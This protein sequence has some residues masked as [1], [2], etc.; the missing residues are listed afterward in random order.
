MK[1]ICEKYIKII[2]MIAIFIFCICIKNTS[3]AANASISSNATVEQGKTINISVN[4]SGVQWYLELKIDG[5]T[6]A[7]SSELDNYES[8]KN[9]SFSYSYTPQTMGIKNITLVGSV[10][11]FDDGS[12]ITSFAGK[13]I[14]VTE[15]TQE[16]PDP[17]VVDSQPAKS[18]GNT[19]AQKAEPVKTK[20]EEKKSSEASLKELIIE[21]EGLMPEF[22]ADVTEYTINVPNEITALNITATPTDTKA[23]VTI[24]GNENFVV[25]ENKVIIKVVAED[26]TTKEYVINV[27]RKR[28]NLALASL[29]IT[30]IDKDGNTQEIIL[31][32]AFDGA[33]LEYNLGDISYLIESLNI[34][35]I[36]NLEGAIVEIS[37][38]EN[39]QE[40]ENIITIKLTMKAE[41]AAE[42]EE[43]EEDE[44][45]I[46]TIKLNKE[47]EPTFWEKLKDKIKGIFG[48]ISTWFN[49]NTKQIVFVALTVCEFALIGLAAYIM[50]DNNKYRDLMNKVKKVSDLNNAETIEEGNIDSSSFA[51]VESI[52]SSRFI[53]EYNQKG[54]SDTEKYDEEESNVIEED[55]IE[56]AETNNIQ[57]IQETPETKKSKRNGKHF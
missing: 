47:K 13:S 8:N 5:V 33:I 24:E 45:V 32:P 49:N 37:G 10:T 34:E 55:C 18:P 23:T 12:T 51:E 44:V 27:I 36:A 31:N 41:P 25:G 14:T 53:E 9:I 6:V 17:A 1:K 40:G 2:S 26:G 57:E 48:G 4:G 29:R 46:Y 42:G 22:S 39:L 21:Q 30:Y 38:N 54:A 16:T 15:P 52:E 3:N 20:S 35:A 50:V 56:N 19:S 28:S 7:K 43:Q 11:E